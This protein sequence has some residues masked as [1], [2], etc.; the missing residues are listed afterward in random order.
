MVQLLM[1]DQRPES[2]RFAAYL[3]CGAE[4]DAQLETLVA[5]PG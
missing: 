5:L 1:A 3:C 2:M 4:M